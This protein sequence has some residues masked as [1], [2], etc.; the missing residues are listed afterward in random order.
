MSLSSWSVA[1]TT[2]LL[3]F[4]E[5]VELALALA[6]L[7]TA[8]YGLWRWARPRIE[9]ERAE[10]K[11]MRQVLIGKPAVPANPIT[12]EPA[13]DEIPSIGA[14]MTEAV[15]SLE[16]LIARDHQVA[17]LLARVDA[18]EQR[19]AKG[20]AE[21]AAM[22]ADLAAIRAELEEMRSTLGEALRT[23]GQ[24]NRDLIPVM[25]AA[26]RATPPDDDIPDL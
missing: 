2:L 9:E 17:G 26:I 25:G 16:Y 6:G 8:V 20:S 18:V 4:T 1:A 14:Q 11:A 12:G 21:F 24:A 15:K 3:A 19:L 23:Q 13:Q 22:H 5:H 7:C 10:R